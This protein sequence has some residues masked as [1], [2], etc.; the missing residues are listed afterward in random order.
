MSKENDFEK[1]SDELMV[2]PEFKMSVKFL[3]HVAM[4]MSDLQIKKFVLNDREFPTPYS[5]MKQSKLELWGRFDNIMQM[6]FEYEKL[7]I[8]VNLHDLRATKLKAK[9]V[10]EDA[11]GVAVSS[12][13]PEAQAEARLE[14]LEAARKRYALNVI[15]KTCTEKL[16]EMKSFYDVYSQ[17]QELDE[18]QEDSQAKKEIEYWVV[19]AEQQSKIFEERYNLKPED[20]QRELLAHE[21][22]P[23]V[24]LSAGLEPEKGTQAE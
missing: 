7:L 23:E 17:F 15:K 12:E 4:G 8:E 6:R 16:R 24:P 20:L 10:L 14:E 5:K 18:L 21:P 22:I 9:K 2:T 19:R 3:D 13:D 1:R 11:G